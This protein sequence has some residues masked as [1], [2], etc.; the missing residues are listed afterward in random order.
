MSVHKDTK[1]NIWYFR[2]RI[3]NLDGSISQV[4][5]R[6]FQ[7]KKEA[8][9]AEANYN[10]I[11]ISPNLSFNGL[12]DKYLAH[13][14]NRL[15]PSTIY[16][17]KLMLKNYMRGFFEKS[18]IK[19]IPNQHVLNWLEML[20]RKDLQI[21]RI[22]KLLA[23]LNCV[24]EYGEKFY[25][26]QHNPCRVIGYLKD[27]SP[28]DKQMLIWTPQEFNKF[29]EACDDINYYT[30]FSILY[31][32]GVR[33][34]EALA[35]TWNDINKY[36]R[37]MSITKTMCQKAD[38][39]TPFHV[40][41]PKTNSGNR[42]IDLPDSLYNIIMR[43]EEYSRTKYVELQPDDLIFGKNKPFSETSI[44]RYKNKK[45]K[46][47]KVKQ[48]RIH[49]FRHSHASLLISMGINPLFIKERLGHKEVS[50]TL[51]IYSHLFPTNQREI[52]NKLN[53]IISQ[54]WC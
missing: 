33:L 47:A 5:I 18:D 53:G 54:N 42:I 51:N 48:I 9:A 32:T 39:D 3:V 21:N 27:T 26:I 45:C 41:S 44:C 28:K 7:T 8:Q 49:D 38:G 22:N 24:L 46:E 2:K 40:T 19:N 25:D 50:T 30:L 10:P 31:Y 35:L 17:K 23:E 14:E 13:L 37:N 29:I 34:G 6:G 11:Q 36:A 12:C 15:K 52:V 20:K 1:Y 4:N 16:G 43:Y